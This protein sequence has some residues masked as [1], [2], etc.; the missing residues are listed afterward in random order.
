MLHKQFAMGWMCNKVLSL[1]QNII[2]AVLVSS[3]FFMCVLNLLKVKQWFKK[4]LFKSN[5]VNSANLSLYLVC[6]ERRAERVALIFTE[7]SKQ[8]TKKITQ[9]NCYTITKTFKVVGTFLKCVLL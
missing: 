6:S 9:K 7:L 4:Q 1:N 3:A 8:K 5:L 2:M